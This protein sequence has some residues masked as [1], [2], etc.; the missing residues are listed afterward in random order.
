MSVKNNSIIATGPL[1]IGDSS[2]IRGHIK[3]HGD[4]IIGAHVLITGNIFADGTIE[5]G[6]QS[7]VLG[8]VFSQQ[9]ITVREN[10][11]IGSKHRI[12]SMIG[13][14]S[15]TLEQGVRVY[16]LVITEGKGSIA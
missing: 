6:P 1:T 11:Q 12:K 14:K 4:L 13:K 7:R 10:A 8:T 2:V 16:G 3:A 15:V 9:H 5:I